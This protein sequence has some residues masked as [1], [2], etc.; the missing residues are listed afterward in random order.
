M[1]IHDVFHASLLE[2]VHENSLSTRH[3]APPAPVIIDDKKEYVVDKILAHRMINGAMHYR[4]RWLGYGP[5]LDT[6]EPAKSFLSDDGVVNAAYDEYQAMFYHEIQEA[7]EAAHATRK[8]RRG[9][10]P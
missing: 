5:E 3:Q 1:K 4:V 8:A 9:A 6:W 7:T 2:P 10:R